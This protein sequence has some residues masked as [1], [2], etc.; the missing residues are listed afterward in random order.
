MKQGEF[1]MKN[2]VQLWFVML[3]LILTC[4]KPTAPD[5]TPPEVTIATPQNGAEVSG[6]TVIRVNAA[7]NEAILK[8]VFLLNDSLLQESE[9][10][11]DP[12]EYIWDTTPYQSG[13]LHTI[14]ARAY[15]TSD[16]QSDSEPHTVR[17]NNDMALPSV[18]I[19]TPGNGEII[20]E[21][22]AIRAL[23]ADDQGIAEVRFQIDGIQLDNGIDTIDP[24]EFV[25]NT[26]AYEDG[27]S[28]T[29]TAT[30]TDV[31]G[32]AAISE[33]VRVIIDNSQARP[34]Q[35]NIL[36]ISFADSSFTV[37]WNQSLDGDFS[38]YKLNESFSP[39]MAGKIEI[40]NTT[41]REDTMVVIQNITEG[42]IRYYQLTI[43][44]T[45]GLE[46]SSAIQRA[47]AFS[48]PSEGLVAYYPFNGSAEDESGN[49]NNGEV[50]SAALIQ[51]RNG[52]ANSAFSFDG[53]NDYIEIPYSQSLDIQ[54]S[55]TISAWAKGMACQACGG[56]EAGIVSKGEIV[57]YGLGVD[58]GDRI[59]FRVVSSGIYYD[60]LSTNT[61][62]D[63]SKWYHY[64]GIFE[65][66]KSIR[67]YLNGREVAAITSNVPMS[68]DGSPRALWLGSR[69]HSQQPSTPFFYFQGV[70]DDIRIYNRA[71][72]E[73]EVEQLFL[74][75]E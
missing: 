54:S 56:S 4:K 23:A 47:G 66:G 46:T 44:D 55:M 11:T 43:M 65:A 12:F 28:H 68:I 63:P 70:I 31:I 41:V 22:T 49:G 1:E 21:L 35:V 58:D 48:I 39:D 3:L 73:N 67:L 62:I 52:K 45:V 25:L 53:V 75:S 51:D 26:I 61:N 60:V 42:E 17:V 50:F 19:V 2:K 7:D 32:N 5:T 38:L 33:Q 24:Y 27:S 59:M 9:D 20:S 16:N 74:E 57:P 71:I 18:A 10:T 15:D 37:K 13:S 64:V 69:A 34:T 29:L 30:A 8:V 14:S 72:N 40:A 36:P 6:L